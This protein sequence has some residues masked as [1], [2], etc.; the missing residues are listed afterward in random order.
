M[1]FKFCLVKVLGSCY[2]EPHSTF[3]RKGLC[4]GGVKTPL[5]PNVEAGIPMPLQQYNIKQPTIA[6]FDEDGRSVVHTMSVGSFIT[7]DSTTF[8]G[9]KLVDV[10]WGGQKV[11]MFTQ[12][13][14]SN[15]EP[16]PKK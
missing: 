6:L 4:R 13:L 5:G 12:D 11:R 8:F 10:T 9:D 1:C 16:C 14:R 15:A 3:K 7:V 2:A